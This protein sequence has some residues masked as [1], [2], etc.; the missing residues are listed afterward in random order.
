MKRI[1]MRLLLVVAFAFSAAAAEAKIINL[2]VAAGATVS[3]YSIPGLD[4]YVDNEGGFQVGIQATVNVPVISVTPELWYIQSKF[5]FNDPTSSG[6]ELASYKV[7]S[8]EL[9]IVAG[10][11]LLKVLTLE[12]GP[13]FILSN[14]ASV[15]VA[16]E[17]Y[18]IDNFN[19]AM[20][21]L[22][23]AKVTLFDKVFV[24]A[25]YNGEFGTN[26]VDM[27]DYSIKSETVSFIVG[28]KF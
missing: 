19:S 3:N 6:S 24:G 12:A 8:V 18:D 11:T 21:Y 15:K 13:R 1:Y 26:S 20:G 28:Y 22:L 23:G 17:S 10:L 2:G 7:K 9:P 25:R 5:A 27:G 16:G 14:N 4:D